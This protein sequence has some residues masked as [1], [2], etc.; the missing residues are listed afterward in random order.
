MNERKFFLTS[1]IYFF[2]SELNLYLFSKEK[3]FLSFVSLFLCFL[4]W[5]FVVTNESMDLFCQQWFKK[6]TVT[7]NYERRI[8]ACRGWREE[9]YPVGRPCRMCTRNLPSGNRGSFFMLATR[10]CPEHC[11][12][13]LIT[14]KP[15]TVHKSATLRGRCWKMIPKLFSNYWTPDP[16]LLPTLAASDLGN[17]LSSAGNT[18]NVNDP[19]HFRLLSN[20]GFY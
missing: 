15:G 18:Y 7:E 1:R 2:P 6:I 19:V 5:R 4:Q 8:S 14:F 17:I 12:S 20:L 13:S 9:I 3:C 10:I 11:L 16:H